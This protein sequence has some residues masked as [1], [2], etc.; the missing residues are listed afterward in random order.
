MGAEGGGGVV[1][2]SGMDVAGVR[3]L[4]GQLSEGGEQLDVMQ[5]SVRSGLYSLLWEGADAAVFRDSWERSHGPAMSSVAAALREASQHLLRQAADQL[6]ASDGSAGGV[7]GAALLGGVG[8]SVGAA[9]AWGAGSR[10]GPVTTEN[11]RKSVPPHGSPHEQEADAWTSDWGGAGGKAERPTIERELT[12]T[13]KVK[14]KLG[15]L[16]GDA[17]I[18][19]GEGSTEGRVG[20]VVVDGRA[21]AELGAGGKATGDLSSEGLNAEAGVWAGLRGDVEGNA[22]VGYVDA[23]ASVAA[24]AGAIARG[25]AKVGSTGVRA[26]GEAFAGGKIGAKVEGD[27]GGVGGEATGEAWAGYGIAGEVDASFEDGKIRLGVS[28]GAAALVGGKVGAA[29]TIDPAEVK[30]TVR[31]LADG[32]GDLAGDAWHGVFR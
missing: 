6:G 23:G 5:A 8:A 4:A 26:N 13:G 15:T 28:A 24:M 14:V 16:E 29:I 27:V 3:Q 30:E 2:L 25:E 32:I 17:Y 7:G 10:G 11:G 20:A 21:S 19:K 31:D 22:S 9:V 18:W 12:G 1:S